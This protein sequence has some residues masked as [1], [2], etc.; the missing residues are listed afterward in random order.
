MAVVIK[1]IQDTAAEDAH[2]HPKGW[3]KRHT[4]TLLAFLGFANIFAMRVNLSVA[5]VQMVKSPQNGHGNN[6]TSPIITNSNK[7]K[8]EEIE[9]CTPPEES[10]PYAEKFSEGDFEWTATEQGQVLGALF[11]GNIISQIPAGILAELIGGKLIFGFGVLI[12]SIMTLLT[13]TLA[14]QSFLSL[15]ICRTLIGFAQGITFPSMYV[16][17]ADWIPPRERN[18]LAV[19]IWSGVQFGTFLELPLSGYLSAWLGW[20]SV[21]YFN[22][23]FGMLWCIFFFMFCSNRPSECKNI[24]TEELFYIETSS[25]PRLSTQTKSFR[26]KL[27][28]LG[29][30]LLSVPVWA[31]IITHAGHNWGMYTLLTEMPT[32]LSSIHHFNITSSGLLSALPYFLMWA[33][34]LVCGGIATFL[35]SRD[36][37]SDII[38]KGFN[39]LG[40]VG[41]ALGLIGLSFSGCDSTAVIFWFCLAV[42]LNGA[43]NS[44]FQV[45][46]V[47]L[48]SNYSGTLMGVTNTAANMAGF[49]APYVTGLVIDGNDSLGAW[50][51]VFLCAAGVY[52]ADS[53]IYLIFGSSKSQP[54]NE[55]NLTE[56][57]PQTLTKE[58][59]AKTSIAGV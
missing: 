49:M 57:P 41:P 29:K 17:I 54:W 22:G 11:Y 6:S 23:I 30:M 59:L 37:R 51:T 2:R 50:R 5:I 9:T 58:E 47:E 34:T 14:Y 46:H 28:P 33:F 48:S 3:G 32:Y 20:Q 55:P 10:M 31:L 43:S 1:Q 15:I 27:P 24:S 56:K 4:F 18:K 40:H 35:R 19:F 36:V 12:S 13:P 39:T 26:E 16:L 21:F 7:T 8:I 53:L 44:G 42:M 25:P 38:R 45:N 52:F